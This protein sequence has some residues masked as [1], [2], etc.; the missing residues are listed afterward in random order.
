MPASKNE[1]L[2]HCRTLM[3]DM[4]GTL[5]DLAY[6][7]FMWLTHVPEVYA[8]HHRLAHDDARERLYG[9]YRELEGTLDW[10]CLDHWSERLDIDVLALHRQ[11][12]ARIDYLPG[13]K[14]F[15]ET[16]AA[17]HMRVLLVTNSHQDTLAL[18][19]EVTGLA[20]Y[21][22]AVYSSH[23]VGHPKEDQAFWQAIEQ[24]E[25]FDPETT[26]FVDDNVSVLQSAARFGAGKLVQV[27]RPDTR[28]PVREP[29]EFAAVESVAELVA[30]YR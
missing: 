15:L 3:L 16:A 27:T 29:A 9:V 6:D 2:R 7:N 14:A 28:G 1:H 22:D 20:S 18:K 19:A 5:L 23:D 13:A 24:A 12:S 11:Q 21:F 8:R 30:G 10:Y 25:P 4:D 26:V 17:S